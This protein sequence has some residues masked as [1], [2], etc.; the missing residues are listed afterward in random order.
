M[1]KLIVDEHTGLKYELVGD[2]YLLT[3]DDDSAQKSLGIW[4]QQHRDYLRKNKNGI[5]TGLWLSGKLDSYLAELN[6]QAE[7]MFFQL[8]N[9]LAEKEGVTEHLKADN[10]MAWVAAMN[11]IRTRAAEIVNRELI[12]V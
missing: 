1:E 12:W 5:Y 11:S 7:D 3:G 4:G 6:Q 8:V 10:Q 2:Y 9:A